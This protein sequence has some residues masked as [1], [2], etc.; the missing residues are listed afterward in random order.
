MHGLELQ[1]QKIDEHIA[2]VRTMLGRRIGR[3]AKAAAEETAA[4][5]AAAPAA[6]PHGKRN[7]SAAARKRI[8]AA[9]KRRWAA[10]RKSQRAQGKVKE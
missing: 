6:A 5:A 1:K 3:P 7:L 8:A 4:P 2:E 9:Q 10:F